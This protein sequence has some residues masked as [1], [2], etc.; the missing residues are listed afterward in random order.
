MVYAPQNVGFCV[1]DIDPHNFVLKA[2]IIHYKIGKT[3]LN[4]Y[5]K[6]DTTTNKNIIQIY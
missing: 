4:D 3:C 2:S 1:N 6:T 5:V